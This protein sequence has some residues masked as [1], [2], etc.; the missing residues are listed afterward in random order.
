MT[1]LSAWL[2]AVALWCLLAASAFAQ[3][4][5]PDAPAENAA[6]ENAAVVAAAKPSA[7]PKDGS[8][9]TL[10]QV[11]EILGEV[12]TPGAGEVLIGAYLNDV[13]VLDL[14]SHSYPGDIYVWFRWTDPELDPMETYEF[15]NFYD[16]E[17]H[18]ESVLYDEPQEMPDGSFYNIIRHQGAFTAPMPLGRYPF[19]QQELRFIVEDAEHGTEEMV[20]IAGSEGFTINRDISLPGYRVGTPELRITGKSYPTIFGDLSNPETGAYSRATFAVPISRPWQTGVIKLILPT[21]IVLLCAG[22][23]LAI[24]PDMS[25]A[26]IGLVITALLT[27]VALQITTSS[28]LPEV[29]YLMVIDQIYILCYVVILAVLVWVVRGTWR[30]DADD[31]IRDARRDTRVLWGVSGAFLLLLIALVILALR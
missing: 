3:S 30:T 19:D 12:R 7:A 11:R 1:A 9:Y 2:R 29:G 23:A 28:S 31:D 6:T 18:I 27:L 25:D 24:H 13:P 4:D 10:A 16:P 15:M 17:A 20:F 21:V 26:R 8:D 5:V 22:L 14:V